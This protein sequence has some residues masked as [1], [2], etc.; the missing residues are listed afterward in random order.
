MTSVKKPGEEISE[1]LPQKVEPELSKETEEPAENNEFAYINQ[2]FTSEI[3]KIEVKNLPK[4]YG[5]GVNT[6]KYLFCTDYAIHG[7][8]LLN[9]N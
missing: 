6:Q 4:H 1:D 3:F 5:M 8:I 2:G 9:R 7:V